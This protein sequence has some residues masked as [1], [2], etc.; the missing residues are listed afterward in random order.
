[1]E[2]KISTS[3][4]YQYTN[5]KLFR[6]IYT[7]WK[8]FDSYLSKGPEVMKDYFVNEWNKLKDELIKK[9]NLIL[10]DLDKIV[11]R[12]DFDITYNETKNNNLVFFFSF[13]NYEYRDGASKYVALALLSDT[14]KF[15]TLEYSQNFLTKDLSFVVGEFL[16]DKE[17]GHVKHN[18]YGQVDN[19]RL[20]YFAG[21]VIGVLE[22][23][24]Y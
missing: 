3:I 14:F 9:D 13:P 22:E 5:V 18:N 7:N 23:I 21:R 12:D 19:D 20:S 1:M 15:F 4:Q 16:V 8:E 10:K 6:E 24:G 11:T 2:N 17:T